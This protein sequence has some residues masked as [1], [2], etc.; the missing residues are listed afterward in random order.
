M[1]SLAFILFITAM[2]LLAYAYLDKDAKTFAQQVKGNSNGVTGDFLYAKY[3]VIRKM[4]GLES[5]TPEQVVY[6]E[7]IRAEQNKI[8]TH[9]L[10]QSEWK[11]RMAIELLNKKFKL[12]LELPPV[13]TAYLNIQKEIRNEIQR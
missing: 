9:L 13:D 10:T 3:L 5:W 1:R 4:D 6:Y 7:K 2:S 8:V 11:E 12:N